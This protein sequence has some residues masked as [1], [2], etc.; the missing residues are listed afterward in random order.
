VLIDE[1]NRIRGYYNIMERE[2]T[3]RLVLELRILQSKQ[4]D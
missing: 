3:D 4:N 2:E 1:E